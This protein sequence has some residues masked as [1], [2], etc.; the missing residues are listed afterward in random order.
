MSDAASQERANTPRMS[1]GHAI[2]KTLAERGV[3]TVFG[4]PGVQTYSLFDGLAD[5]SE[6]IR[7]VNARHEFGVGYMAYGYARATGRIGVASVVPGPGVLNAS[8]ALNTANMTATPMLMATGQIPSTYVGRGRGHLHEMPDQLATLRTLTKHAERIDHPNQAPRAVNQAIDIA[9][10]GRPGVA[11]LEMAWDVMNQMAPVAS[12]EAGGPP[13]TPAPDPD[14]IDRAANLIKKAEAPLIFV[15]G[16]AQDAAGVIQ[17]LAERLGAPVASNRMGRGVL[18][19][20]H[21]LAV[22]SF[23]SHA[24]W[25]KCDLMIAIGTR[26]E[27]PGMRWT[28]YLRDVPRPPEPKLVRI[29]VC[30]VE[31]RRIPTD[32]PVLADAAAGVSAL[33]ERFPEDES[34]RRA[35]RDTAATTKAETLA[36]VRENVQPQV[37]FLDAIR[38]VMPR[39][40]IFVEEISQMGFTAALTY[41]VY[42]PRQYVSSGMQGALGYGVPTAVGVQAADPDRPV[43]LVTGDG[44]FMFGLQEIAAAAEQGLN[45]ITVIVNNAG[46]A[47]VR[48]DQQRIFDGRDYKSTFAAM[49]YVKLGEALGARS[50]KADT[51]EAVKASLNEALGAGAPSLIEINLAPGVEAPPWPYI[52]PAGP[53]EA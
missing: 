4:L 50:W 6:A 47:N 34:A 15:G 49:D 43:V 18:S 19:S 41:P 13:A 35:W 7:T 24:L 48:R 37:Q 25:Q 3:D 38:E 17:Q 27:L 1:G 32:A 31:M 14:D 45:V 21:E 51:P 11:S 26:L 9:V 28:N 29:E 16:G 44:G 8:S 2:V 5:R 52:F 12:E 33:L 23:T 20:D 36:A 39:D 46:Y 40:S 10:S 30:P 42:G 53:A 22:N